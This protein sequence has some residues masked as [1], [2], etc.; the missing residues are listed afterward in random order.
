M[1]KKAQQ[2]QRH[3][4]HQACVA[5]VFNVAYALLQYAYVHDASGH[6]C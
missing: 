5:V 3:E 6:T 4:A 1:L 2:Q